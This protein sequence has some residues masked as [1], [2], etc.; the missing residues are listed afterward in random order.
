MEGTGQT[1]EVKNETDDKNEEL[2]DEHLELK[3]SIENDFREYKSS[4][5][6]KYPPESSS[7]SENQNEFSKSFIVEESPNKNLKKSLLK[8][9]Q[10]KK[11]T[12]LRSCHYSITSSSKSESPDDKPV[13]TIKT[14]DGGHRGRGGQGAVE[15]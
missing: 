2:E 4:N 7:Y 1:D 9:V 8:F 6:T 5:E 11:A 10:E 3:T 15:R 14:R 13:S 12:H